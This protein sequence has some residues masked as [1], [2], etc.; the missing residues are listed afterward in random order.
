MRKGTK[1]NLKLSEKRAAS[2]GQLLAKEWESTKPKSLPLV[3]AKPLLLP[4]MIPL[5]AA[6]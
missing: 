5:V 4:L 3:R 6:R 2:V 1:K